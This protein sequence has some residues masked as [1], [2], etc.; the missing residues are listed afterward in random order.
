M[1]SGVVLIAL[2][3]VGF[4]LQVQEPKENVFAVLGG[5]GLMGYAVY[6]GNQNSGTFVFPVIICIIPIAGI[7][8]MGAMAYAACSGRAGAA[9]SGVRS[10]GDGE[11]PVVPVLRHDR[12]RD[13]RLGFARSN[14]PGC[15]RQRADIAAAQPAAA[16]RGLTTARVARALRPCDAARHTATCRALSRGRPAFG[17][18]QAMRSARRSA[19][20]TQPR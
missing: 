19:S 10:A 6:V 1:L 8:Y 18:A 5:F 2:G 9:V 7:L 4:A 14:D 15:L 13:P 3:I 11:R 16:A 17:T 12:A 20:I